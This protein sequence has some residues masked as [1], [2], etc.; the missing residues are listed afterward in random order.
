MIKHLIKYCYILI[1]LNLY[2]I[3]GF[4]S[5][6]H[7]PYVGIELGGSK[8]TFNFNSSI[9]SLDTNGG[10]LTNSEL[11]AVARFNLGYSLDKY[12]SFELGASYNFA[13]NYTYPNNQGSTLNNLWSQDITYILTLPTIV[14]KLAI[15]GRV[16]LAYDWTHANSCCCQ[17]G[18]ASVNTFSD[19]FGAGISYKLSSK[20]IIRVEWVSNGLFFPIGVN[21]GDTNIGSLTSNN[22]ELGLNYYF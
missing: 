20:S 13:F 3:T 19:V 9:F 16:G 22:F 7:G 21:S 17:I 2:S 11:G 14:D 6:S 5:V 12:N 1:I 15:L 18:D 4:A 8:Q 10:N